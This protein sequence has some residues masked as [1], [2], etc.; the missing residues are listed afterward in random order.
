[1]DL[2]FWSSYSIIIVPFQLDQYE[3]DRYLESGVNSYVSLE[4]WRDHDKKSPEIQFVW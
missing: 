1:M 4:A 2:E 3:H